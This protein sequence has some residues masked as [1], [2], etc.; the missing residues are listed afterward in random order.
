MTALYL[1]AAGPVFVLHSC[2]K[3][4]SI[5]ER[6]PVSGGSCRKVVITSAIKDSTNFLSVLHEKRGKIKK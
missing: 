6:F 5:H 4:L 2:H 1:K 3:H